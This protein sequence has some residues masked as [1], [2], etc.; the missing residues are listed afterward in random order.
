MF[1]KIR[2]DEFRKLP[3]KP[4]DSLIQLPFIRIVDYIL[5]LKAQPLSVDD[6]I[7]PAYF[8][9]VIDGL[10]YELYFPDEL[11]RAGCHFHE[12]LNNLPNVTATASDAGKLAL[13]QRVFA[14]FYDSNHPVSLSLFNLSTVPE[15]AIIEGKK[16]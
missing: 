9:Q 7:I 2:L 5:F 12:H 8:E 1:P 6:Q 11:H 3:V 4:A 10:V 15:V 14:Q 13:C 16:G